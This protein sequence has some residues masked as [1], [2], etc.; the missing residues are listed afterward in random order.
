MKAA[1]QRGYEHG[2]AE[3]LLEALAR[4]A[5]TV[6]WLKNMECHTTDSELVREVL[7]RLQ[8]DGGQ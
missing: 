5:D 2:R 7:A 6:A 4:I 8:K 3:V 1:E